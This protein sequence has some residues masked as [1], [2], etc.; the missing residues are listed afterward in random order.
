[1][2]VVVA[3]SRGALGERL[4]RALTARSVGS[5]ADETVGVDFRADGESE[6]DRSE[7]ASADVV[8]NVGGPRVRPGLTASDYLRE[9]VG[10]TDTVARVMR[11]GAHLVHVSST[12]VFGARGVALSADSEPM[13]ERFPM[14]EYAHAKWAAERQATELARSLGL[15]LSVVRPSMVY[16]PDVDSALETLLRLGRQRVSL[17]LLPGRLYQHLLHIELLVAAMARLVRSPAGPRPLLLADPFVLENRDLRLRGRA[18]AVVPIPLGAVRRSEALWS[19]RARG[20]LRLPSL[21]VLA[22]SN[23]FAVE[24][25]FQRLGLAQY[26]FSRQLTFDRYFHA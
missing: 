3:G 19:G 12:A 18:A 2:K 26:D 22:M 16:G 1:M 11:R 21:A 6:H 13:P 24:E 23:V 25:T 9:H 14:P 8:I 4:V 7:L 17:R 15:A 10:V 20:G 5:G